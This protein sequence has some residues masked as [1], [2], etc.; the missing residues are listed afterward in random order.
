MPKKIYRNAKISSTQLSQNDN[1]WHPN[2]DY[3]VYKEVEH[4]H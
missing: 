3:Q 2:K 4:Y 1:V